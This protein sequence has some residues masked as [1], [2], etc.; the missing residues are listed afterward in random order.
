MAEAESVEGLARLFGAELSLEKRFFVKKGNRF[1]LL[2]REV[3]ELAG[4]N[5]KWRCAGVYLGQT[6]DGKFYPSFPL[7]SMIA[8]KAENKITVDDKAAWLFVCGRDIFK[9]GILKAEGSTKRGSYT[10]IFN[11]HGEC[12]GFG[13][14][15]KSLNQIKS[16]MAVENLLDVGDFLRRERQPLF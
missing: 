15:T 1:F 4:K 10:L 5:R 11:K 3:E 8:E 12:L 16:G 14:I 7:L 2:N 9:E 6:R 13:K